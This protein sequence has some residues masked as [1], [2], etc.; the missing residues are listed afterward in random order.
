MFR[1]IELT[2]SKRM[3]TFFSFLKS[4]QTLTLRKGD[5]IKVVYL[6][7]PDVTIYPLNKKGLILKATERL[8]G[9]GWQ[10]VRDLPIAHAPSELFEVLE[11]LGINDLQATRQAQPLCDPWLFERVQYGLSSRADVITLIW[12]LYGHGYSAED[13]I[14]V[15]ASLVSRYDLAPYFLQELNKLYK[16]EV[17]A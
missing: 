10:V 15:F 13:C 3:A 1:L 12:L 8:E 14:K 17:S 9:E 2:L 6:K 4:R 5:F 7:P 16:E 11:E